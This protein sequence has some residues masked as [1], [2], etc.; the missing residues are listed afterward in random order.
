MSFQL[1]SKLE[2]PWGA[3][4]KVWGMPCVVGACLVATGCDLASPS[5]SLEEVVQSPEPALESVKP[6]P[7]PK[8]ATPSP[9]PQSIPAS[10]TIGDVAL[11]D[12]F[13]PFFVDPLPE[14]QIVTLNHDRT[15][16]AADIFPNNVVNSFLLGK[17]NER[18]PL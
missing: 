18:R 8:A 7:V 9:R 6:A 12:D 13:F 16:L 17:L 15:I 14:R 2:R 11:I 1:P 3:R 10:L 5:Q 4:W